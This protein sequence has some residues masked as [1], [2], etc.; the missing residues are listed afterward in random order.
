MMQYALPIVFTLGVWWITTGIVLK[1]VNLEP[2]TYRRS[3]TVATAILG[4]ALLFLEWSA[5]TAT[6]F[7]AY[8]AF[9]SGLLVW[10][11][12]EMSYYMGLITGPRSRGCTPGVSRGRRFWLALQASLYHELLIVAFG[13]I[14]VALTWGAPNQVGT[15]TFI[16]LWLMRWSAKLN[17]FLGVPN[18]NLQWFPDHLRYLETFIVK[19]PMNALFPV[20]MVISTAAA[21]FVLWSAMNG[22]TTP[23]GVVESLLLGSLIVLAI[24]EHVFLVLPVPDAALWHWAVPSKPD[25]RS[26]IDGKKKNST[27][28]L[29][30]TKGPLEGLDVTVVCGPSSPRAAPSTNGR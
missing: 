7:S 17:I 8:V 19:K 13:G 22:D 30:R 18:L 24:L 3:L 14:I 10:G 26:T 27:T 28:R 11:W 9:L 29:N 21:A 2:S 6:V 25:N 20:S 1:V 16:I 15:W 5:G 12:I 4:G 23:F